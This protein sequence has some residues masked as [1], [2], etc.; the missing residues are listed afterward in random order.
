MW[1]INERASTVKQYFSRYKHVILIPRKSGLEDLWRIS[2]HHPVDPRRA[3]TYELYKWCAENLEGNVRCKID[4]VIWNEWQNDWDFNDIGGD[5]ELFVAFEK[6]EDI[7]LF[8]L[9]WS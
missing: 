9:K 6:E 4:R 5:E 8:L 1:D 2:Q 3:F 7:T